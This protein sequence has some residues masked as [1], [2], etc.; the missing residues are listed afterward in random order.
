MD[1]A[2]A[3]RGV[4][5]WGRRHAFP[6]RL[7]CDA[8]G[9]GSRP[10]VTRPAQ[11]RPPAEL[12]ARG[13]QRAGRPRTAPERN[14]PPNGTEPA[15]GPKGRRQCVR[16]GCAGGGRARRGH[17]GRRRRGRGALPGAPAAVRGTARC[18]ALR[19]PD[20]SAARPAAP[21]SAH[22]VLLG[23]RGRTLR[24][25]DDGVVGVAAGARPGRGGRPAA[26]RARPL[27]DDPVGRLRGA[28]GAGPEGPAGAAAPVGHRRH[29]DRPAG[30]HRGGGGH[31]RHRRPGPPERPLGLRLTPAGATAGRPY[32]PAPALPRL[33]RPHRAAGLRAGGGRPDGLPHGAA[34]AGSVLRLRAADRTAHRAG[35]VHR[36]RPGAPDIRRVRRRAG[37]LHAPRPRHRRR[38]GPVDRAGGDPDDRRR[39]RAAGRGR[40]RRPRLPDRRRGRGDPGVHRLHVRRRAAAVRGRGP[41]GAR[42]PPAGAAARIRRGPG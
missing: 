26:H 18:G 22:L 33:V 15:G 40:R 2:G 37:G 34:G 1:R 9:A 20:R 24:P 29:G 21:S 41:C 12:R 30:R 23:D 31:G 7:G 6:A 27:Q 8:A 38:G 28:D 16:R 17:R 10:A 36:V 4:L 13:V 32:P 19:G 35:R 39:L 42:G 25:G 14:T 11:P 5:S 3:H